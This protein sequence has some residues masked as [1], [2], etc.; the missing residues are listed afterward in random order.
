MQRMPSGIRSILSLPFPFPVPHPNPTRQAGEGRVEEVGGQAGGLADVRW[1]A[2]ALAAPFDC[3]TP[4]LP[5]HV[6]A[7][8]RCHRYA[9]AKKMLLRLSQDCQSILLYREASLVVGGF[10]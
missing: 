4:L 5:R 2:P 8:R 7:G 9:I 1:A 3:C 10:S 6:R